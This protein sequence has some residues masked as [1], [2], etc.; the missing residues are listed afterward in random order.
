MDL[1]YRL[2]VVE[3]RPPPLR[4]RREDIPL[5]AA[6]FI[7]SLSGRLKKSVRGLSP[8]AMTCLVRYHWPGNVRELAHVIE[9]SIILAPRDAWIEPDQL[10]AVIHEASPPGP[11]PAD[12]GLLEWMDRADWGIYRHS[13]E[14]AGSLSGL[15][16][17]IEARIV[18]KAVRGHQGNKT[19]AA[20]ALRR[21][22]RWLRKV[23]KQIGP[24]LPA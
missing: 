23:E 14:R 24:D 13:L 9:R 22:Y 2:N 20:R 21:S 12:R 8:E 6:H 7:D 11:L 16:R 15:I 17:A 5:L 18:H 19:R 3:V 10:P 1:Y 4:E